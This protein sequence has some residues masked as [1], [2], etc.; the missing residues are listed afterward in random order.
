M[1]NTA[2][3]FFYLKGEIKTFCIDDIFV[4]SPYNYHALLSCIPIDNKT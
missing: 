1:L 2:Q 4:F 3:D